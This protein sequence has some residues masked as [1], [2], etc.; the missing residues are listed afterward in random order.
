MFCSARFFQVTFEMERL[1]CFSYSRKTLG[2][3]LFFSALFSLLNYVML[4]LVWFV[5][6]L[7]FRFALL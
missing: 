2:Y 6:L 7:L 5:W 4:G 1:G 3:G